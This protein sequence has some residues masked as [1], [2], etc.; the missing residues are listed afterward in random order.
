MTNIMTNEQIIARL[1]EAIEIVRTLGILKGRKI[2]H[3]CLNNYNYNEVEFIGESGVEL[4]VNVKNR[5][6]SD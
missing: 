3:I 6:V 5:K 1:N 4:T 2:K